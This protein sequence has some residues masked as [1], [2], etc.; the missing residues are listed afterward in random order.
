MGDCVGEAKL[1]Q[2]P[3][4]QTSPKGWLSTLPR[5]RAVKF[6]PLR[7]PCA[8]NKSIFKLAHKINTRKQLATFIPKHLSQ[9][10]N[11]VAKTQGTKNRRSM[12]IGRPRS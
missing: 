1:P 7:R 2:I 4:D 10:E 5:P 8:K 12:A 11:G 3:G 6:L 9:W